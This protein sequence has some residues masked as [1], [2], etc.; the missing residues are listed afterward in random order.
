MIGCLTNAA[1][2]TRPDLAAATNNFSR[3]Q[4]N[5]T[6]EHCKYAKRTLRCIKATEDLKLVCERH[7][8]AEPIVGYAD[9]DYITIKMIE[10]LFLGL[11][12]RCLETLLV[13]RRRNSL[14]LVNHRPKAE[15]YALAHGTNEGKWPRNLLT[16]LGIKGGGATFIHEED[17]ST[18]RAAESKDHKQMKQIDI[19][20]HFIRDEI[21]KGTFK[22][23]QIES[24]NQTTDIMTKG[25]NRTLFVKHRANLN[26]KYY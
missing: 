15:Y 5:H 22:L 18:I 26:L 13:G 9:T 10:N 3:S 21:E 11:F 25:L 17:T 4:C 2:A 14:V 12:L 7:E 6:D 20:H 16:E 24:V 23:K 8:N 1:V 19:E